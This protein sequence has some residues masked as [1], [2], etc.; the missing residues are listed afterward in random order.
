[1]G[2]CESE[3]NPSSET[4]ASKVNIKKEQQEQIIKNHLINM[5]EKYLRHIECDVDS[6]KPYTEFAPDISK[7]LSQDICRIVIETERG[8]KIGTGFI[9]S[10]PIDIKWFNC[11]ITNDHIINNES[12]NK[13]KIIYITYEEYKAASIKLERNKRYIRSFKDKNLDITV[14]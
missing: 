3:S 6:S 7:L 2:I 1:M 10:F 13:N 12:I 4:K 9:L 5:H 11:L 8:R 14:V